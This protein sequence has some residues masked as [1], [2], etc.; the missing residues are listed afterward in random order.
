MIDE[1][2]GRDQAGWRVYELCHSG[3]QT[4]YL[5]EHPGDRVAA[6]DEVVRVL[7]DHREALRNL[8]AFSFGL[9]VGGSITADFEGDLRIEKVLPR[10]KRSFADVAPESCLTITLWTRRGRP[11]PL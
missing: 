8:K 1:R 3:R 6:S 7:G 5:L 11:A 4:G 2:A 10:V 9:G